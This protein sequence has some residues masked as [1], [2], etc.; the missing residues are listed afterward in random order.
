MEI[1][2]ICTFVHEMCECSTRGGRV[3]RVNDQTCVVSDIPSW[4]DEMTDFLRCRFH[5]AEVSVHSA[6]GSLT[7]FN[8][9][10]ELPAPGSAR[11]NLGRALLSLGFMLLVGVVMWWAIVGTTPTGA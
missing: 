3:F 7:G 10:V 2:D 9:V 11:E 4:T 6:S 5:T 8:V 1:D